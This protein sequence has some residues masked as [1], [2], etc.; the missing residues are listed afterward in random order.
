MFIGHLTNKFIYKNLPKGTFVLDALKENTPKTKGGNYK[1]RL[2][3]SL[4]EDKGREALKKV[5]YSVEALASISETKEQF[6]QLMEDKYGQQRLK[7]PDE[8]SI[9]E[10][11]MLDDEQNLSDFNKNLKKG[12]S[13]NPKN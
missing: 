5:L 2:H 10:I 9:E 6:I 8:E 1:V 4:T 12:L 11:E 7:F 13:F 3:Q